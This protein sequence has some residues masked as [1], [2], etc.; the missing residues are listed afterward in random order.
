MQTRVP[1]IGKASHYVWTNGL[2]YSTVFRDSRVDN[3]SLSGSVARDAW[4]LLTVTTDGT[5]Y[6]IF[7]NTVEICN[8]GAEFTVNFSNSNFLIGKSPGSDN[9]FFMEGSLDDIRLFD[10]ALDSSDVS[11]LYNSGNGRGR[12]LSSIKR[13]KNLLIGSHF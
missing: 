1:V 5:S 10:V 12:I 3:I 4:H 11:Y 9:T 7:Q 13:T 8:V 6:K 2:M